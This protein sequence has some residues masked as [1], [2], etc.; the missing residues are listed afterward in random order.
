MILNPITNSTALTRE[1]IAGININPFVMAFFNASLACAGS[2]S[3]VK[4]ADASTAEM[5]K[6]LNKIETFNGRF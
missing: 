2:I 5:I 6:P 1:N 3:G 4:F